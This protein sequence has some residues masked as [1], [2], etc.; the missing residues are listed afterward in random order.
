MV[1]FVSLIVAA[2]LLFPSPALAREE[3]QRID[4]SVTS[5]EEAVR[6][7]SRQTG[8]S[9]GFRDRRLANVR[10]RSVRGE[11][12]ASEAL[13]RMLRGTG[14]RPRRVASNSFLIE[15]APPSPQPRRA[16]AAP[17]PRA[18]SPAPPPPLVEPI[19]IV[20]TATKRDMPISAYAGMVHVI[21][22]DRLSVAHGRQG[23]DA[24]GTTAA[25]V[26]S[27]H[28][29][30]GRNKLFIR[31]IADSSFVG[32][33]QSTVGQYWGQSRITYAAPDPSLRLYDV[34]RIEVLEGPQGTLYGA[35]SLGGIVRVVPQPPRL[36]RIEGYAWAGIEAVTHGEVGYDGG[37][38]LNLPLV[39]DRLALRALAFGTFENGYIDDVGRGLEDVNDVDSLGGRL[40]LRYQGDD[41]VTIDAGLVGQRIEG[42]DGQYSEPGQGDLERASTIAQPFDNEFLLAD[43]VVNK[44]WED[45]QL[46]LS[47][48]Y[49]NQSVFEAF[50]GPALAD[51]RN[52]DIAPLTGGELAGYTQ[53]NR[54]DMFTAEAR[55]AR[56]LP[57]GTGWLIAASY[58]H[59]E[60]ETFRQIDV[61]GTESDLTGVANTVDELTAY[62][63]ATFA[64]ASDLTMT[65]GGRVTVSHLTGEALTP[66]LPELV[67]SID[68]SA[69]DRRTESEF[70]PSLALAYRVD[71]SLTAFLRYQEGF[72][73]GGIAV[74]REF[75]QQFR[76]D[77]VQTLEAGARYRG[78]DLE[79]EASLSWTDWNNI[80]ADLIDGYG[81]PTTT[82]I[83][84][85]QVFSLGLS[86]RWRLT[87]R[88]ELEGAV[89]FNESEVTQPFEILYLAAPTVEDDGDLVRFNDD[90]LPNIADRM[91]HAGFSWWTPLRQ[92]TELELS[93]YARYVGQSVLGIGPL[94]GRLQ[95]DY[96][97]TGIEAQ[98]LMG[99][100]R[101][102][103]AVTN[104]LDATG[105][106]FALGS[107]FEI[108]DKDQITPLKPRSVRLGVQIAF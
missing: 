62:G 107:P 6:S 96:I 13:V 36:D 4:V 58:L 91:A 103:L 12:T 51:L 15:R 92:D 56:T 49:A 22:G 11:M 59:N 33:T 50:E 20:V 41:G 40:A 72:R 95:G 99:K 89:Y 90:R 8:S 105:N 25:S 83:G 37:G 18:P 97:D 7:L 64:L 39:E 67:L 47:A 102:S 14:A 93:G 42:A 23:T 100:T 81:F 73:P 80:Q 43:L 88:L 84:D 17:A 106:R 1:R 28:Q 24:L 10:V 75:V 104:L 76:S 52:S 46:T 29:G 69:D 19:E 57:D 35:G 27:T 55:L 32:P 86:G 85:G 79:L 54:E 61:K 5:L 53:R 65:A 94:L 38:V 101:F 30:P 16:Q 34:G 3:R 74:R 2:V 21:E 44:G 26:V 45:L 60:A 71:D 68:P 82:N 66:V 108:R 78:Q 70:L 63:E 31:G 9:I 77:S 87:P 98:L 48:A